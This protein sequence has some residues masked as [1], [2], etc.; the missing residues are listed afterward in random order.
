MT[1]VEFTDVTFN[2]LDPSR[3]RI[4][5]SSEF[6]VINSTEIVLNIPYST[7]TFTVGLHIMQHTVLLSQF[8]PS[9]CPSE[10]CMYCDKTKWCTADIL[11]PHER[12]ITLVFWH[13][14]WLV[15]DTP[16][17]WNTRRKWPTRSKNANFC[18]VGWCSV[19][20]QPISFV[21]CLTN[22]YGVSG[23]WPALQRTTG[24][25]D[26]ST[27]NFSDVGTAHLSHTVYLC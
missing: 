23:A 22:S 2:D 4:S 8:C 10:R 9:V 6:S 15:G 3:T 24:S 26:N 12:A 14:H 19:P 5:R 7:H 21:F 13:Q 18:D 20:A 1:H 25:A 17:R 27:M 11:I 16:S